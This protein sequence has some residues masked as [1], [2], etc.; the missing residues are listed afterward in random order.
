MSLAVLGEQFSRDELALLAD[1]LNHDEIP[2][3]AAGDAMGDYI[4][5]IQQEKEK[6]T[7][8]LD[9]AGY[10]K[11]LKQTKGYGGKDG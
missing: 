3:T 11:K 1:I 4:R 5:K 7:G 6:S 10:A 8:Q 9:L 2:P